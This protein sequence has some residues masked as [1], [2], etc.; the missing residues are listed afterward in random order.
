[1]VAT[2]RVTHSL[3]GSVHEAETCWY[4]V[5]R[6]PDWVD[7]LTRVVAVE[8]DWPQ[9]GAKVIWESGPAGRGRVTERVT[10]YEP[11]AGQTVEIEDDS[12]RGTQRVLFAPAEHGAQIELTL[13]YSIKRRSPLTPLVDVLFV[14]RP[15]TISLTKTLHRFGLALAD[16]RQP[17]VG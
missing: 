16:S 4:D 13:S 17:S 8:G 14:R 15:M 3:D 1:M 11:L 6:W 12:I 7:G 2:V 5:A 10:A 9:P